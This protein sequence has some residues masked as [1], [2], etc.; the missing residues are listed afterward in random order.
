MTHASFVKRAPEI[1]EEILLKAAESRLPSGLKAFSKS[2][3]NKEASD[4]REKLSLPTRMSL[5]ELQKL[6]HENKTDLPTVEITSVDDWSDTA[7]SLVKIA[8][9]HKKA[10]EKKIYEDGV[11]LAG[12]A[13]S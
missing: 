7:A 4:D 2:L 5:A 11:K 9:S 10:S 3:L 12:K 6:A 8:T 13:K 1:A